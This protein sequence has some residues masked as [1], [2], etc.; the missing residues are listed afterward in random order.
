[1]SGL[2]IV[3]LSHKTESALEQSKALSVCR[4]S[5][6]SWNFRLSV[7]IREKLSEVISGNGTIG[8]GLW[9]EETPDFRGIRQN[10][11]LRVPAKRCAPFRRG[12]E[13]VHERPRLARV[14][15]AKVRGNA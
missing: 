7:G 2:R 1:M 3:F 12:D 9:F 6:P 10:G 4:A 14:A 8:G 5:E 11:K 13:F 15:Y